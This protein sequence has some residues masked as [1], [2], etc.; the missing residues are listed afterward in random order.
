MGSEVCGALGLSLKGSRSWKLLAE[1]SQHGSCGFWVPLVFPG[2]TEEPEEGG[3][4][5]ISG[6]GYGAC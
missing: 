6:L 1:L 4:V 5:S 3:Q 2:Q